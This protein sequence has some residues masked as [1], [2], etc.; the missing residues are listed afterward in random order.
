MWFRKFCWSFGTKRTNHHYNFHFG[1][2]EKVGLQQVSQLHQIKIS[3]TDD[4]NALMTFED[5]EDS[6]EEEIF[7]SEMQQ[8][9]DKVMENLPENANM[10]LL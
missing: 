7:G 8:K 1:L 9:L 4:E 6:V 2:P 3:F 5:A 10:R